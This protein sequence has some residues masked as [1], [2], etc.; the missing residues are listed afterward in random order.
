MR[1]GLLFCFMLF[2]SSCLYAQV[3]PLDPNDPIPDRFISIGPEAG[4]VSLVGNLKETDFIRGDVSSYQGYYYGYGYD[5]FSTVA[6]SGFRNFYGIKA[7]MA[8]SEKISISSGLRFIWSET[9]AGKDKYDGSSAWFY[10]LWKEDQTSSDY[11]RVSNFSQTSYY[12]GIPVEGKLYL[13]FLRGSF[14]RCYAKVGAEFNFLL[15]DNAQVTLMDETMQ[16]HENDLVKQIPEPGSFNSCLY[17]AG[18]I[19]IGKRNTFN[20][21]VLMPF[22]VLGKQSNTLISQTIGTGLKIDFMIPV[23]KL[24]NEK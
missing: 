9:N 12:L 11:L 2:V 1:S 8:L 17:G 13:E 6:C 5:N 22:G 7:E 16:I 15:A 21:E 3:Y 23:K 18:G 10:W 14:F 20:F 24:N 19:T 4:V